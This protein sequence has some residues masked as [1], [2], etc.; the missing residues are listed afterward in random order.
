MRVA[1]L[2]LLSALAVAVSPL[3]ANAIPTGPS[4]PTVGPAQGVELVAGGSGKTTL[5]HPRS[6]KGSKATSA[7]GSGSR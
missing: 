2:W 5:H 4:V 6:S 7:R 1:V 3:S